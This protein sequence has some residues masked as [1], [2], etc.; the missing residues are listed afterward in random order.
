MTLAVMQPYLFPYLGYFQL[1]SS[2]DKFIIH[3]DVQYIK[4][5]WINNNRVLSNGRYSNII[6]PV[7]KASSGKKI[8]ERYFIDDSL[9]FKLKILRKLENCYKKAPYFQMIYPFIT[10]L[11]LLDENNVAK[12]NTHILK[13][14]CS[15]LSITTQIYNSSE[16]IKDNN[17]KGEE[18]VINFCHIMGS[19]IYINPVGGINLYRKVNFSNSNIELKFLVCE[20][21]LYNQFG[22]VFVPYL[23]II[24]ILMFNSIISIKNLLG[25]YYLV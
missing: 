20:D 22:E 9:K 23:S 5:G 6:V 1:I 2:V 3:D 19:K 15:Y 25:K 13:E 12:F 11:L 7:I 18:R 17:L 24:D 8:N 4:G 21:C 16:I 10:D 14:V